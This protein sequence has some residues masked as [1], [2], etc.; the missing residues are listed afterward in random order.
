MKPIDREPIPFSRTPGT[1]SERTLKILIENAE[2]LGWHSIKDS[3]LQGAFIPIPSTVKIVLGEFAG[4]PQRAV[5]EGMIEIELRHKRMKIQGGGFD[6]EAKEEVQRAILQYELNRIRSQKTPHQELYVHTNDGQKFVAIRTGENPVP[7]LA[8][9]PHLFST[10]VIASLID[11]PNFSFS[12]DDAYEISGRRKP[13][14]GGSIKDLIEILKDNLDVMDKLFG[15][16]KR[17]R[18]QDGV[19]YAAPI[20]EETPKTT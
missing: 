11:S 17:L 14:T 13:D 18:F 7:N 10:L 12:V 5:K 16:G 19:Y 1:V 9:I 3:S 4:S 2:K 15:F 8:P 20:A 6:Q